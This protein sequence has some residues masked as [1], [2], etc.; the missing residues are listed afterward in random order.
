MRAGWGLWAGTWRG[1][2][3]CGQGRAGKLQEQL[4]PPLQQDLLRDA[5]GLA[6][7]A[8]PWVQ[9]P[10]RSGS[11]AGTSNLQALSSMPEVSPPKAGTQP[12]PALL[13]YGNKPCLLPLP[14]KLPGAG[15]G[16]RL[17][18]ASC[19]NSVPREPVWSGIPHP[20]PGRAP[21]EGRQAVHPVYPG[22][23]A[24]PTPP[25]RGVQRRRK[26]G[27]HQLCL[28][29]R[30]AGHMVQRCSDGRGEGQPPAPGSVTFRW[31]HEHQWQDAG[32]P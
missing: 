18:V 2:W 17:K 22:K 25:Q 11:R 8:G 5:T 14:S 9:G 13:S 19:A 1:S 10:G 16:S 21:R 29:P 20:R 32:V 12:C 3:G 26:L 7:G 30:G 15:V 23:A 24:S 27:R 28:W 4:R 31:S 6:L